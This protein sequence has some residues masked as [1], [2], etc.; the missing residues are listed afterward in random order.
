MPNMP[1][2]ETPLVTAAPSGR[3]NKKALKAAGLTLLA[4]L[5]L[6][7]QA[8]TGYLV[9]GQRDQI[10]DLNNRMHR[11]KEISRKTASGSVVPMR[12]HLPMASM[13]LLR[14]PEDLADKKDPAASEAPKD[15]ST[16]LSECQMEAQGLTNS[17]LPSFRPQ[18][19]RVGGYLPQQCWETVCWC[20]DANG[21][22]IPNSVGK[23]NCANGSMKVTQAFAARGLLLQPMVE[24]VEKVEDN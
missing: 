7:G 9:V 8:I 11:L 14:M 4:C 22:E 17:K 12:M 23:P 1:D 18:C 13:P 15:A 16:F 10:Q 3:S 21:K 5:L 19:D 20:V 24:K 6:A 2:S